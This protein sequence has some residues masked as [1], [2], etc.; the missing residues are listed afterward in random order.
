MTRRRTTRSTRPWYLYL[1]AAVAAAAIVLGVSSLGAP[2]TSSA[3]TS[4][5]VVAAADGVVQNTVSGS[6]NVEPGVEDEVNFETSGTLTSVRVKVGQHVKKGELLGTLDA[7]SAELTLA[8][9]RATLTSAEDELTSAEDDKSSSK[10]SSD[11]TSTTATSTTATTAASSSASSASTI[12]GDEVQIKDDE[13]TVTADEQALTETKLYAPVSGT[14]AA[15]AGDSVGESVSAGSDS[16]GDSDASSSSTTATGSSATSSSSSSAFAEIIN[17]KTMTMTV[18]LSESDISSIK[19]GQSAT[20]SFTA[21]SGVE[22]A[23]RVTS[24]SPLG[25]EDDDVVSYD[26][27]LTIYQE[28]SKVLPGMSATAAI[29]T[30]QAQGVTVPTDA[31]TDASGTTGTV[32]VEA[33]GKTVSKQVVIG[34]KGTDRDQ[35][36]S[37]LKAGQDVVVTETLPSLSSSS[38]AT[39]TT[40]TT[41]ATSS[42]FGGSSAALGASSGGFGGGSGSAGPP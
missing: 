25:T 6:G 1:L 3:R 23:A 8:G 40:S 17:S 11:S 42:R 16:A 22:L 10:D 29:I 21:L 27:T 15:T 33:N 41:S 2:A 13:A 9:A 31:V 39:S 32:N 20:V 14:V 7:S 38:S 30:S 18:S 5:E 28:N 4:K 36:I 19:V 12:D 26:A 37:G 34:L 24:I 35:I